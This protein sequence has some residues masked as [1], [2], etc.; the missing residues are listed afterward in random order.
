[1]LFKSLKDRVQSV[2]IEALYECTEMAGLRR[3]KIPF[4]GVTT[5]KSASKEVT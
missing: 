1:M 4:P 2:Q 3:G 5:D